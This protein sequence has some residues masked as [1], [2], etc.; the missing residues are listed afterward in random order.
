MNELKSGGQRGQGRAE[1]YS[2]L[3]WLSAK[4]GRTGKTNN[5]LSMLISRGETLAATAALVAYSLLEGQ[6][7]CAGKRRV[8]GKRPKDTLAKSLLCVISFSTPAAHSR[9]NF[10][11]LL[12]IFKVIY[13]KRN[14]A[15]KVEN[16]KNTKK[17]KEYLKKARTTKCRC[18]C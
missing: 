3:W 5:E 10:K 7:Q 8:L 15:K 12:G 16:Q 13:G 14:D 2:R 17:K 11:T 6:E 1:G 4:Q 9:S 18:L